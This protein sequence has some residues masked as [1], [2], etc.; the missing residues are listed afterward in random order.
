[1]FLNFA[2]FSLNVLL[3]KIAIKQKEY[4]YD[5]KTKRTNWEIWLRSLRNNIF[6][7]H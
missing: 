5:S 7:N 2:N 1:M 3:K 6:V 4:S